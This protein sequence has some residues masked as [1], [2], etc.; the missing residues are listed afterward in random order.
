[1]TWAPDGGKKYEGMEVD[2]NDENEDML[3]EM[4]GGKSS[5]VFFRRQMPC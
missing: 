5:S 2:A 4:G 3:T 1:M